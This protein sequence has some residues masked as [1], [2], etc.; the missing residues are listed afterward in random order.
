MTAFYGA[1][2]LASMLAEFGVAVELEADGVRYETKGILDTVDEDVLAAAG[3]S[4]VA[5]TTTLV[6]ATGSLGPGLAEHATP[7]VDGTVRRV[8]RALSI[9]DGALTRVFFAR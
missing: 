6:I 3:A 9:D 4:M 1:S 5:R 8:V 7:T 2:D